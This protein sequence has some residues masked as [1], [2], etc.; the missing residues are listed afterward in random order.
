MVTNLHMLVYFL[1]LL[2]IEHYLVQFWAKFWASTANIKCMGI[3]QT[4][5]SLEMKAN[6]SQ[7]LQYLSLNIPLWSLYC[8]FNCSN[9]LLWS[10]VIKITQI[11]LPT[12]T[13]FWITDWKSHIEIFPRR[14]PCIYTIWLTEVK[15]YNSR[16]AITHFLTPG[17]HT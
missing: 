9:M 5:W 17:T 7:I 14:P 3:L 8:N 1:N 12:N 16:T 6:F 2:S 15:S 4:F 10:T 13:L 11:Q